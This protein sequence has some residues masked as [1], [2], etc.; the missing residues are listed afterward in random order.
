MGDHPIRPARGCDMANSGE[1]PPS[2]AGKQSGISPV[3]LVKHSKL[4]NE[5]RLV[6]ERRV[7]AATIDELVKRK[8][9]CQ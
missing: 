5:A 4:G 1:S 6:T 8:K 2:S 7:T 3:T 9:K